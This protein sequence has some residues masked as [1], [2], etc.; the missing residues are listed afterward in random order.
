MIII[1]NRDALTRSGNV[2][3]KK[4]PSAASFGTVIIQPGRQTEISTSK[5]V[6]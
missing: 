4:P 3:G 5:M 1:S 6:T 2:R